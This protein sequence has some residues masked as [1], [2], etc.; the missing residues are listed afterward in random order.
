MSYNPAV[1]LI[2]NLGA[3]QGVKFVDG[4]P[5]VSAT[6]YTFDIAEGNVAGHAPLTAFGARENVA[7]IANGSDVWRGTATTQPYPAAAGEQLAIASTSAADASA[8]TG[9]RSVDIHYLD[10]SGNPQ[11]ETVVLNGVT[12]VLLAASAVRFVQYLHTLSCG[13]DGVAVGDITLYQNGDPTRV[14][15]RISVGGNET[16]DAMRMVPAGQT[17][18][19]TEVYAT[20]TEKS[21]NIRLRATTDWEGVLRPDIFMAK[22]AWQLNNS[23]I[24]QQFVVPM[25][26]PALT[27][28]KMTAYVPAGKA[29]ADIS[30]GYSGWLE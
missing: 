14:Y 25:K 7:V 2:D 1:K 17:F 26:F 6:P 24:A 20:A 28:V 22:T 11:E 29:G 12:P 30:G 13:T 27:I 5:R 19:L 16:V 18:Y 10:A 4:K 23:T 9:V 3:P 8:G 15:K 21:V